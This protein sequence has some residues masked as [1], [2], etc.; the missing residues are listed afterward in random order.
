MFKILSSIIYNVKIR[1][2]IEEVPL[3]TAGPIGLARDNFFKNVSFDYLFVF[4]ADITCSYPLKEL[5]N[6]HIKH[7]A[8]GTIYTTKV[9]EPSKYGVVVTNSTGK[10]LSFVEKP[11]EFISDNINAGLYVFSAKFLDRIE[12]KPT[13]IE[14]E[15][16]PFLAKEEKMY[17]LELPGFWMDIGQPKD[18]LTGTILYLNN[19]S[20][21]KLKKKSEFI[22]D[23][24]LA[25]DSAV[26]EDGAVVGPN[27]VLGKNVIVKAGARIKNSVI[28]N[29]T[30]VGNYSYIDGSI[31]GWKN[32]IGKWVRING[33]TI[34]G[35]DVSFGDEIVVDS[36]II[37]PNLS[38]KQNVS[39][40]SKVIC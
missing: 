24:V 36:S 11:Q 30:I 20:K 12:T 35:E 13:S 14:K 23:C 2:S 31:I 18:Y 19:L 7:N 1:C 3:G 22:L 4:N 17:A 5:L 34:S 6:F 40:G 26:I 25:D 28:L 16:F 27:V 39:S 8:E 32:K 9:K 10:I 21:D 37:L 15:V 38:L 33:L 29:D